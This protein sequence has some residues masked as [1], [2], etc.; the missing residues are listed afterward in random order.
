MFVNTK[1][2][3]ERV[4]DY[5]QANDIVAGLTEHKF[6]KDLRDYF[7]AQSGHENYISDNIE[8]FFLIVKNLFNI[9]FSK[10]L[11]YFKK[12]IFFKKILTGKILKGK[13]L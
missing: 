7:S 5:L 13:N 4:Q 9:F 11:V 8:D 10:K 6:R 3:A 1:R 12:G 2:E